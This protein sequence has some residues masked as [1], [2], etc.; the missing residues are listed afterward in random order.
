[1]SVFMYIIW[2][3]IYVAWN[4]QILCEIKWVLTDVIQQWNPDSCG[5]IDGFQYAK[6]VFYTPFPDWS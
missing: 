5:N 6:R 1:M 3:I 4:T 2:G